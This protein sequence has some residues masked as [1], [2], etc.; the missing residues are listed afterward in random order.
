MARDIGEKAERTGEG[1]GGLSISHGRTFVLCRQ[2]SFL[3]THFKAKGAYLYGTRFITILN[4]LISTRLITNVL[5]S[6]RLVS[7]GLILKGVWLK[8][9]VCND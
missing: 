9:L 3:R 6:N 1:R 5:I 7:K 8:K 2:D 4:G